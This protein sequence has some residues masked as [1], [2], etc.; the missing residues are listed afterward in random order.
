MCP[1]KTTIHRVFLCFVRFLC[2]K[3]LGR[4]RSRS[5]AADMSDGWATLATSPGSARIRWL[6]YWVAYGGW[7][8]VSWQLGGLLRIIPF[9]T[10]VQLALLLWLQVPVFRG[11]GRI[12]DFGER[13]MER[14]AQGSVADASS[15][16]QDTARRSL[17]SQP[18]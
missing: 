5:T 1:P 9:A 18:Q 14:W 4:S 12:L 8:H 2:L 17:Q 10:H 13:C 3:T 15:D 16:A 11:G 6:T 7:W